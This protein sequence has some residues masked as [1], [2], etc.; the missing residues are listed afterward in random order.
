MSSRPPHRVPRRRRVPRSPFS[1]SNTRRPAS[2]SATPRRGSIRSR[3]SRRTHCTAG[4]ACWR[5]GPRASPGRDNWGRRRSSFPRSRGSGRCAWV[6]GRRTSAAPAQ[7]RAAAVR[8]APRAAFL[9]RRA[10]PRWTSASGCGTRRPYEARTPRPLS[11][12]PIGTL[13]AWGHD[14]AR[15]TPLRWRLVREPSI[16]ALDRLALE[17][18]PGLARA[19][20][21]SLAG[22]IQ[23]AGVLVLQPLD[24]L[25]R[26]VVRG[27]AVLFSQPLA[28]PQRPAT[29]VRHEPQPDR[30][31][32]VDIHPARESRGAAAL[33]GVAQEP[34]AERQVSITRAGNPEVLGLAPKALT[35]VGDHG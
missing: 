29:Q 20:P 32:D 16:H 17:T 9:G 13:P 22:R 21:G 12:E 4:S 33:F 7:T 10:R 8:A 23:S 3:R 2:R 25:G 31:V 11:D 24:Q 35:A 34:T 1:P 15:G 5:G 27:D 30:E 19:D 28:L 26:R 6:S 18:R 14:L